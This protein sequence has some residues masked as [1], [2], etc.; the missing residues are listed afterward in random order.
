MRFEPLRFDPD[1][2]YTRTNE[3]ARR[4]EGYVAV[5]IDDYS[6]TALGDVVYVSLPE[7]GTEV[8]AG[9]PFGSLEATKAVCDLNAPVSGVVLRV[10][11]ALRESP[12]LVNSDPFGGGWMLELAPSLEAEFDALMTVDEYREYL[13]NYGTGAV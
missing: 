4:G 1:V 10:N 2:R 12:G 7:E 11:A 8:R 6:Q 3:W 13:K 9:K 5:G